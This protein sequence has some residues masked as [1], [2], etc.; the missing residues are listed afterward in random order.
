M[1]LSGDHFIMDFANSPAIEMPEHELTF[2]PISVP[3]VTP[4][5]PGNTTLSFSNGASVAI[6]QW[7]F[8][9]GA[10]ANIP[11]PG[12]GTLLEAP[13]TCTNAP[14]PYHFDLDA[15]QYVDMEWELNR[16]GGPLPGNGAGGVNA[17]RIQQSISSIS[18]DSATGR[19]A[20]HWEA[21]AAGE[22]FIVETSTDMRN[23]TD[24]TEVVAAGPGPVSMGHVVS[25]TDVSTTFYRVALIQ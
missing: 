21:A 19:L 14:I 8:G 9:R 16:V 5:N 6:I 12:S 7:M 23:W 24:M 17:G 4:V 1:S 13:V 11:N 25:P 20:I 10:G 22:R 2:A 15:N 18:F 3:G